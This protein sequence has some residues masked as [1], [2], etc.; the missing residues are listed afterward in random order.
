MFRHHW[1]LPPVLEAAG[2]MAFFVLLP[3]VALV[4]GILV[5]GFLASR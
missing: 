2:L 3:I 4:F 1:F 5:L